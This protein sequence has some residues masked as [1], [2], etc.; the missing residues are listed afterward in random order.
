MNLGL[1]L[2]G[3]NKACLVCQ[4]IIPESLLP[5]K[6]PCLSIYKTYGVQWSPTLEPLNPE[7]LNAYVYFSSILSYPGYG[8][9]GNDRP[10]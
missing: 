3:A 1:Q 5:G 8:F 6:M 7:A 9:A 2:E 10:V 4:A